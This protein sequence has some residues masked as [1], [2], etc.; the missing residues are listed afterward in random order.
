M[1]LTTHTDYALRLLIYLAI[2]GDDMPAT[3]QSAAGHYGI[4]GHHLAKVSQTLVQLGYVSSL[5][6]RGGGLRL[7]RPPEE[8]N[9]GALIRQTENLELLECFGPNSTCP[10]DPACRL[11]HVLW[12]AQQAFMQVLDGYVL[13]DMIENREA[14]RL[15]ISSDA[16]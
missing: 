2:R 11:K 4:S 15:L 1:K 16:S 12:S 7:N 14:L 3:V 5:R 8:I 9:I 10:I 13:A 6:G